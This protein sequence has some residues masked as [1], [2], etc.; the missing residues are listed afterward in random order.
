MADGVTQVSPVEVQRDQRDDRARRSTPEFRLLAE[1]LEPADVM[2]GGNR[3]WDIVANRERMA[4][5]C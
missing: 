1:M 2:L 4:R 3:P 5:A